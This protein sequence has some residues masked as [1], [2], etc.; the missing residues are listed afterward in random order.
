MKP[1]RFN[2]D[3]EIALFEKKNGPQLLNHSLEF[4]ALYLEDRPLFSSKNYDINFLNHIEAV[5]GFR[6]RITLS[7]DYENWW[8]AMSDTALEKKLNSKELVPSLSSECQLVSSLEELNLESGK[9]YLAKNPYGMS[10]QN[11]LVFQKGEESKLKDLLFQGQKM[12]VEPLFNRLRDF[13]HYVFPDGRIICYENLVD[14][15]FQYKGTVFRDLHRTEYSYLSFYKDV[16]NTKWQK[17]EVEFNLIIQKLR[18]QGAK[19]GFSIDSFTYEE[20]GEFKIR[21]ISEVNYRKTMGLITWLLSRKY[22]G[23]NTWSM[24]VMGKALKEKNPFQYVQQRIEKIPNCLHLSPG[25]TRFE[26]FFLSA[27]SP[28]EGRDLFK[29]LKRLLPDC[30]FSIEI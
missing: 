9:K 17:F 27:S 26:M 7:S 2:A 10:G 4:L 6:P 3:Y 16:E 11:F 12:I 24:L 19:S 14:G 21:T 20:D 22:G 13:S 1:I 15:F 25:N 5:S 28:E 23:S 18:D 30:K 8:G 29:E